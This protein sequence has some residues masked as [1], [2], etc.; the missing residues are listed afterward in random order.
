MRQS[1]IE[2]RSKKVIGSEL[3]WLLVIMGVLFI[4]MVVASLLLNTVISSKEKRI[5]T[6]LLK[7]AALKVVQKDR[8][9]EIAR[10][11]I[12]E[13]LREDI[14]TN[15]RLKKENIKN[16]FDLVPDDIVL[17]S[18]KSR[19]NTLRLRGMTL[20][21]NVYNKTFQR[22]LNS[23]FTHSTTRFKK[24]EGGYTFSNI[25]VMGEK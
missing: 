3:K 9:K 18:A 12:L 11:K 23:I 15:N 1:F 6:I 22:S 10:Y 16:F 4:L 2:P 14:S 8:I 17:K 21:K 5:D 13:K 24:I 19:G 25:S 7:E 20:S